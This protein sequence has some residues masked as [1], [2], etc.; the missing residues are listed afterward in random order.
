MRR[1]DIDAT[2]SDLAVCMYTSP[3]L[4]TP[5]D[6][7]AAS[8]QERYALFGLTCEYRAFDSVDEL[9]RGTPVLAVVKFSFMVD[10]YVTVLDVDKD[11]V[12]VGDPAAGKLTYT[13]QQFEQAS[14]SRGVV[15]RR[16][17]SGIDYLQAKNTVPDPNHRL[18]PRVSLL[19]I[20]RVQSHQG[21]QWR[22]LSRD[23]PG[24][25]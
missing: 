7:L 13:R 24:T 19:T 10:H 17:V 20:R 12:V 25:P 15:L 1:L 14:R 5:A 22:V 9:P 8:L 4:G 3:A 16:Q 18:D 2:E 21:P 23:V 6:V 11:R